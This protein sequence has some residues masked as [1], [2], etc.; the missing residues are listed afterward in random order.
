MYYNAAL[1]LEGGAM[2]GLYTSGILDVL[3]KKD[4]Q[5][6]TV[7][8][9]SAG[10][11]SGAN[12]VSKQYQRTY[13]INIKYR[14]DKDYISMANVLKKESIINLDFLF[15]DHGP[16]WHNFD[17]RA[18]ERSETN[19][20][21]VATE[22]TSGKAVTFNKPK[23]GTPFITALEAS[24]SMPLISKPVETAKGLCL[25]GGIAD[26]I[27]YDIAKKAGIDKIV[28]VRTR[29]R[30]YQKKPTSFA[31]QRIYRRYF[32]EYPKFI[33]AAIARPEN[34]NKSV[35]ELNKL[36]QQKEVFVLAPEHTVKVGRLEHNTK[37]LKELYQAGTEDMKKQF[38]AM[39]EYLE[40]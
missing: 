38:A 5:F 32:K 30:E 34:Y 19:F 6:K 8:G 35:A 1:V 9:V 22:L 27:P 18:Y 3:L 31:L 39:I 20:V 14:D 4:I 21:V 24:S 16:T 23:P 11:L 40:N 17:A 37:K 15:A 25:D 2:R 26:S 28:V 13:D 12:Y 10:S 29:P 33:E 36:E 7:I